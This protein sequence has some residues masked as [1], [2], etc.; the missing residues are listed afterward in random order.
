MKAGE[1]RGQSI[2][3]ALAGVTQPEVLKQAS[4]ADTLAGEDAQQFHQATCKFVKMAYEKAGRENDF[5]WALFTKLASSPTWDPAYNRF[6]K[7]A[8]QA[9]GRSAYLTKEADAAGPLAVLG[10]AGQGMKMGPE[11]F[12]M[13]VTSGLLAGSSLGALHWGMNRHGEQDVPEVEKL[14]SKKDK[15]NELTEDINSNLMAKGFQ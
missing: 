1:Y 9:L 8:Y 10:L 7:V 14:E 13:L 3:F 6:M 5:G 15:Y 12:Q 2:A 4:I 11:L